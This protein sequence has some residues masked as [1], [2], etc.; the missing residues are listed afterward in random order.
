[1]I[2]TVISNRWT[3]PGR[4]SVRFLFFFRFPRFYFFIFEYIT[5]D[6]LDFKPCIFIN[7]ATRAIAVYSLTSRIRM[8]IYQLYIRLY[9]KIHTYTYYAAKVYNIIIFAYSRT[10]LC[11]YARVCTCDSKN[12]NTRRNNAP[13]ADDII[14]MLLFKSSTHPER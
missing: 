8:V 10:N 4:Q 2:Y 6:V 7:P 1:M 12:F 3:F 11:I 14:T 9:T 5:S 13:C